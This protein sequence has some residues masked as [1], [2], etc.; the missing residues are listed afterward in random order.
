MAKNE[1]DYSKQWDDLRARIGTFFS[2][3]LGGFFIMAVLSRIIRDNVV[4]AFPLW[5]IGFIV[6]GWHWSLF[7]CPRCKKQF[8]KPSAWSVNQLLGKC[9]HC[10]LKKWTNSD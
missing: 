6:S 8:F 9:P 2:C 5:A 10:G 1:L 4:Y 7:P 3:W